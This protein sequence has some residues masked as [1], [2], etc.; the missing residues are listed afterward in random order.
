MK[1]NNYGKIVNTT[2]AS[3]LYG[4]YGQVNYGAAKAGLIGLTKSSFHMKFC[5][6]SFFS[7]NKKIFENQKTSIAIEGARCGVHCNAVAPIAAS[8]MTKD[9]FPKEILSS[10]APEK[11]VP[12][13]LFLCHESC[14]ETGGVFETAGGWIGK[15]Q[16]QS[17]K[18]NVDFI[19]LILLFF[20][21]KLIFSG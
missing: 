21:I 17:A 20:A 19:L 7:R 11:V 16:I 14:D 8:R 2:S 5:L 3:G 4:N 12:L 6:E 1:S 9:I 10:F 15:V 18:G 13:T